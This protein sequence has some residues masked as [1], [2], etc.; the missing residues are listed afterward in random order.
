M[1]PGA[2]TGP[3]V[4]A[5]GAAPPAACCVK[6]AAGASPG[7]AVGIAGFVTGVLQACCVPLLGAVASCVATSLL[8]AI[9]A[10][11]CIMST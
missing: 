6:F 7:A 10:G 8:A 3:G 1:A 2:P 4:W 9:C 5:A 11:A